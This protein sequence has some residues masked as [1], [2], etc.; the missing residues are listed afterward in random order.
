M[1]N[2]FRNLIIKL[3]A[4][5]AV[6]VIITISVIASLLDLKLGQAAR[7]YHAVFTNVAGLQS[8][9][10]VRIA[11]VEVGKVSG[12]S[13]N[14]RS[15]QAT[16]SFSVDAAQHLTTTSQVAIQ[17][18]NLLGQRY[19]AVLAGPGGQP[20]RSGATIPESQTIPG[21]DLTSVFTGFQPLLAALNPT[22]V[23]DLTSSI[24]QVLQGESGAV[25]NLL[26]QTASI[27]T[28]LAQRQD[29]INQVL[30]NLSPL[31]SSVNQRD[32]Q[33]SQLI[34]GLDT[35]VRGLAGNRADIGNAITSLSGLTSHVSTLLS[36]AQPALDQDIRGLQSATGVLL[37]NQSQLTSV[38]SDL[39]AF[40][41]S[42]NKVADS[43]SYLATYLCNLTLSV[44]GPIS[45]KLSPTVPQSPALSI[46]TGGVG[47]QSQHTAVCQ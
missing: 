41:A 25:A 9:D 34:D 35:L 44:S 4:F 5:T 22:Q 24:I 2:R 40:L 7:S 47:D 16:V 12:V 17:F 21:L 19:L 31:L 38:I 43:G 11:G 6:A 14:H 28:N 23:N 29:V 27:T 18:E 26:S 33:L 15:Y 39:P 10:T 32:S 1:S 36:T 30:D 42:V 20:L 37:A 46:P 8:G 3:V 45:I 13:V